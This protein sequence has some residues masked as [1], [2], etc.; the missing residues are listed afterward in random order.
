MIMG[1]VS[2]IESGEE[3]SV[4]EN[5]TIEEAFLEGRRYDVAKLYSFADSIPTEVVS[6]DDF[7]EVVS[8]DNDT[9][10]RGA[11]GSVMKAVDVVKEWGR[12]KDNP[13]WVRHT[14]SLK[15]ASLDNPILVSHDGHVVDGQHRIMRA[16]IEGRK[17]IRT[18]RLPHDLP[19]EALLQEGE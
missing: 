17:D 3:S 1:N 16:F 4:V 14:D 7:A 15:Y 2:N 6:L 13:N 11:D 5:A 19:D 9:Q 18:K 10:W 8:E 12:Y